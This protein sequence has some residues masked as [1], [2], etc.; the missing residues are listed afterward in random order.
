MHNRLITL[1][2]EY[3]VRIV[4]LEGRLLSTNGGL[5]VISGHSG[6]NNIVKLNS[7]FSSFP[8]FLPV[9][10]TFFTK[11]PFNIAVPRPW[12]TPTTRLTL[13][14]A[15]AK[16]VEQITAD[17]NKINLMWSGGIDSTAMVSAFLQNCNNLSQLRILYSPWSTYEHLEYFELLKTFPNL[18]LVDISGDRYLAW[19]FDGVTVTGDGGDE[20][21]AS[22]DQSFIETHGWDIL[23]APWQDF[24]YKTYPDDNFIE[25]CNS[26]FLQAG[27]DITTVLEARWWFY[28]SCKSR[29]I[30][31]TKYT[32][33]FDRDKFDINSLLGFYDSN[34]FESYIFWNIEECISS[35]EYASWKQVLKDYSLEFDGLA[36][37]AVNKT[38]SHST[39]PLLYSR[40]K[41]LLK[42]QNWLAL[43]D[44][45][46]RISTP[47][48]PLLTKAEYNKVNLT[49]AFND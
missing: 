16:R 1:N 8:K 2:D 27:R 10:R 36:N 12:A 13:R 32:L 29:S 45:G 5:P 11:S 6:Y 34:E 18:E 19:D 40:K 20:L 43:L 46:N 15:M 7:V 21:M 37:W 38:K 24:F 47:S 48:L 49:W 42:N 22:L 14:Q 3:L 26:H 31:N 28:T 30:L 44:D 25:F 35:T 17:S 9:D 4:E 23:H 33:L 39:Q 41:L